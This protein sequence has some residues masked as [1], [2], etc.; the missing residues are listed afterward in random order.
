[1]KLLITGAGGFVGAAIAKAAVQGG[2]QV[3]ALARASAPPRL[4]EISTLVAH[5][6]VDMADGTELARVLAEHRPDVVVHSAW[7]GIIGGDREQSAQIAD[8]VGAL[9]HM[10]EAMALAGVSRFVGVGSQAEYGPLN[11]RVSE[12]DVPEP[13]SYY[14][15]AKLTASHVARRFCGAHDITF[16]WARLFAA[17]GPGDNANWLIPSLAAKL[18]TGERPRTTLG[19]QRWD[20]LYIDD[21][22]SG[23]L[24][25]A[26]DPAA[27]GTFNLSS[28]DPV[29]VRAIVEKLRDRFAPGLDLIF[30]EVPFGPSQ[31]MHL[32]GDP[33][34]LSA[35]TGWA[36]V[37]S[38][39]EGLDRIVASL[40]S[41]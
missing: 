3:V 32:E 12:T 20:Y 5:E 19:T 6:R 23:L 18:A 9:T 31:I 8:N 11:R 40:R 33:T 27:R 4:A 10:L 26:T 25:L 15:I 17:Y 13:D 36:P 28:G 29:P 22:G 38:L 35:A 16:A 34:R 1:M 30:G 39:D 41:V 24:A 21:A 14:G 37:V 2:H 7:A